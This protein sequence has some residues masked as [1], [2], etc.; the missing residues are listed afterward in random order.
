MIFLAQGTTGPP[1]TLLE[2]LDVVVERNAYG[3]QLESFEA[4]VEVDGFDEPVNGVFI[5]APRLEKIGAGVE[6]LASYDDHPVMVRQRNILATSFHPE[7]T[8]ETRIHRLLT[9]I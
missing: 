6:V 1:Q 2:V 5:R 7:L 8:D 9:E 4:P 3:A